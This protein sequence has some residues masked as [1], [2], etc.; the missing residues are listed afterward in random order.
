M[1]WG[2][3]Y[4]PEFVN[5]LRE[6]VS[7]HLPG[8]FRFLCLT[9][10]ATGLDP[11]I[12]TAPIPEVPLVPALLDKARHGEGWRKFALFSREI[13]LEGSVLFLDI[14]IAVT[15]D[16]DRF[17]SY[18]PGRFCIIRDW[19]EIRR[20]PFRRLFSRRFHPSG[21]ANSSVFRYEMPKHAYV[22]DFFV[23]NQDW[24]DRAFHLSQEFVGAAVGDRAFWPAE[25]VVS[26][27]RSCVPVFPLNFFR[28]PKEPRS[29]SIIAFHGRP[30]PDEA[31]AGYRG[32]W[33]NSCRPAPW[34]AR[35]WRPDQSAP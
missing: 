1:K 16:L 17:F 25:W 30:N 20:Q 24:A 13:G 2:R 33:V 5:A 21:D 6:A 3:K 7:R 8:P 32:S 34:L 10:D 35:H 12:E 22:Y 31:I 14:D 26:F 18:E 15:G 9:D 27:K 28:E 23:A 29:A 19:L 4:G 11:G